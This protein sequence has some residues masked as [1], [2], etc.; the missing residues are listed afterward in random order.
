LVNDLFGVRQIYPG[1]GGSDNH[2]WYLNSSGSNLRGED[3]NK[4]S[5][6]EGTYYTI[7][8]DAVRG[9]AET[10]FGYHSGD[11]NDDHGE[12]DLNEDGTGHM[13]EQGGFRDVEMTGYFYGTQSSGDTEYVMY[14]RGGS[15]GDNSCEGSAYKAA[16]KYTDGRCRVRKE[17]WHVS[18]V[19]QD[20]R[21][22]HGGSVRNKWTGMKFIVVNRGSK[23]NISVYM[24]IWIDKGNNNN[25]ER[26][27][28]YTDDGGWGTNG[29]K[30]GGNRD[31]VLTWS[32]PL[33][34]F[35]WDVNGIRFKK[36]SVRE[37]KEG[38]TFEPPPPGPGP[39]PPPP[40][41]E[42]PHQRLIYPSDSITAS[43]DNGNVAANV[44]DQNLATVWTHETLPAWIKIDMLEE[45]TVGY[46][47]IAFTRGDE[48]TVGFNIE[49]SE[50]N[51]N[52]GTIF[53]GNS[54]GLTE[55]LERFDFTDTNARFV[56]V[57]VTANSQK[58]TASLKEIEVWGMIT[59][60]GGEPPPGPPPPGP[61]PAYLYINRRHVYHVNYDV[62]S[63]CEP[64]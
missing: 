54:S 19:D 31:Q 33:A 34:V 30:C 63:Q 29:G 20:W 11:I 2:E 18:Y 48:R 15:H 9:G 25:W 53:T 32:G 10:R 64:T 7:S 44:N 24:E 37:I 23:P 46:V 60:I 27:Y 4:G 26:V 58:N 6:S 3:V 22:G 38:S 41:G 17:Q 40:G 21:A 59:V 13:M 57:N 39:S 49:L 62:G 12:I 56:R 51:Q 35:R 52:W 61:D 36:L 1:R 47:K 55:G 50:D 28:T 5:D 16:V 45:R 14:C 43:G 8:S 42:D